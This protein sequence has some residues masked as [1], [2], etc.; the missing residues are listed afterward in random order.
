MDTITQAAQEAAKEIFPRDDEQA[1]AAAMIIA[2]TFTKLLSEVEG[3]PCEN[4][5][6]NVGFRE[7]FIG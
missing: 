7:M 1:H 5:P 4:C 6:A 3:A 2:R